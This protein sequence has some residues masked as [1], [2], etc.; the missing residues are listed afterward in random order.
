MKI[1]NFT[2]GLISTSTG[3]FFWGFI[4]TIYFQY[5]SFI[6][7]WEVVVHRSIWTLVILLITTTLLKKWNIFINIL[8]DTKKITI[9]FITGLLILGNWTLWIYAVSTD[10]IIDSSFG[11]FIFPIISVFLG[12]LFLNEKL[13]KQRIVSILL[14]AVST[15]YLLLNMNSFPW[16]GLGVAFLWSTYNLLRKKINVETDIGLLIESLFILPVILVILYFVISTNNND[17]N[18]HNLSLASLI[19]LAGPMTLIPLFLYVKGVELAGLGPAGM[20][21]FI[22]PTGQ[23]L[24]GFF[25]FNEYFSTDKFISFIFIWIAVLIYLRDLYENN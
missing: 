2:K 15:L 18:I 20:V 24:L 7:F 13:N 10:K 4:G 3:S 6:G 14:V 5:I 1:S 22:V 19:I 16:V 12:F 8:S 21:F 11:Y 25:Y 23:F 17:F 9:L